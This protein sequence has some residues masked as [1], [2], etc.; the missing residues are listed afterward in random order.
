M[1]KSGGVVQRT[2]AYRKDARTRRVREYF[3]GAKD[4]LQPSAQTVPANQ[5]RVFHLGPSAT[6]ALPDSA[7]PIGGR[8]VQ[9]SE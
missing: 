1:S 8:Q 3:Y 5:L 4:E 7:L 9:V 2:P 6:A